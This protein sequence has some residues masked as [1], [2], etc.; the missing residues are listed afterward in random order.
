MLRQA[1]ED[2][3]EPGTR[4]DV[5]ELADL[6]QRAIGGGPTAGGVG[7]GQGLVSPDDRRARAIR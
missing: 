5:V 3:G 1:G 2:V 4:V 6:A 7:A